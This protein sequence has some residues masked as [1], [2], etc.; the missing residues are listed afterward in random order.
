MAVRLSIRGGAALRSARAREKEGRAG[1]LCQ[2]GVACRE[3]RISQ[4]GWG[5]GGV[6]IEYLILAIDDLTASSIRPEFMAEGRT[7]LGVGEL[8][9]EY[10]IQNLKCRSGRR[11][12]GGL[13]CVKNGGQPCRLTGNKVIG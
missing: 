8:N 3:M 4:E 5:G 11:T 10:R 6:A 1:A 2:G 13:M 7:G 12:S 9:L